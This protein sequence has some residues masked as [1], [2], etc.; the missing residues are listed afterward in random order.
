MGLKAKILTLCAVVGLAAGAAAYAQPLRHARDR[1]QRT[2]CAQDLKVPP[3]PYWDC[4]VP[5]ARPLRLETDT[6][7]VRLIGDVM[8]HMPQLR[9][10]YAEFF[11]RIAAPMRAAD[12][13]VANMEFTL[14]GPPYTGYPC[15]SAPDAYAWTACETLGLDLMLTANNHITDKGRAGLER[16]L[17]IYDAIRDSLGVRQTGSAR[18]PEEE[19]AQMPAI[20]TAKGLTIAFVNFTYGTNLDPTPYEWPRPGRMDREAVAAQIARAKAQ[21]ADFI[22]ALPHWGEEYHL[23]HSKEQ[24]DWAAWLAGEGVDVVVG[25]HPHVVQDSTH[26]GAVPV[27]YSM[28]NA[29]S[30]MSKENTRLEL[31]VTLRFTRDDWSG[32]K[33]MLEPELRFLWCTLPGKLIPGYATLFVDEWTG[34]R[35]EWR[36]KTDYDE[37]LRTLERVKAGTGIR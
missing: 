20:L 25:A 17:E 27:I 4:S 26:I 2:L 13:A 32:R 33:R 29:V 30:N 8:M 10:D 16:T 6:V 31:M 21:K 37:M 18:S 34:H 36:D 35:S 19:A 14:A 24:A 12:L 15:F 3:A 28:G 11:S 1:D 5:A 7:T 22:V 23:R 9:H